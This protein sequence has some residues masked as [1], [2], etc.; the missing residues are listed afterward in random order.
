MKVLQQ[1]A[2]QLK[3]NYN[4]PYELVVEENNTLLLLDSNGLCGWVELNKDKLTYNAEQMTAWSMEGPCEEV[5]SKYGLKCE[6]QPNTD[7]QLPE[8]YAWLKYNKY[9]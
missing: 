4:S 8:T 5:A 2:E 1:L 7:K 9:E 3:P 6:W